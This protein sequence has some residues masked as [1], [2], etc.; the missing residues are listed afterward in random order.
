MDRLYDEALISRDT[1][2]WMESFNDDALALVQ[3]GGRIEAVDGILVKIKKRMAVRVAPNHQLEVKTEAWEYHAW[4]RRTKRYL[5]RYDNAHGELHR[6][7][8]DLLTGHESQGAIAVEDLPTLDE[9]IREAID[10]RRM[11]GR[12]NA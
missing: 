9:V 7:S 10:L 6:H 8:F 1:L 2:S 11:I 3:L 12:L 5:V 4:I